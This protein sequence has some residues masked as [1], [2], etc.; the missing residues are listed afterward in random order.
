M[1]S[2]ARTDGT[3]VTDADRADAE[4]RLRA[5]TRGIMPL[6][7][8]MQFVVT[9]LAGL[10]VTSSARAMHGM[11]MV[12]WIAGVTVAVTLPLVM[13]ITKVGTGRSRDQ[14]ALSFAREREMTEEAHRREFETRLAN[15]LE[16]ADDEAEVLS[17]VGRALRDLLPDAS[18]E[19]LLADNSHAHL[20]RSLVIGPNAEGPG[21]TVESP[22]RCVAARRGQT[23]T[24]DDSENL[25]ACSHLRDRP[26]GRCAAM[27][28]P[29]SIMGRTVG[30][31]HRADPL[32]TTLDLSTKLQVEV[33]A[34]QMGA[35]IGM[36]RV[37]VESQ[38]QASTDTVTGLM[39]RRAFEARVRRLRQDGVAYAMVMADLDHFKVLNDTYG[40][41]T[42]DRALRMFS[43]VL[44]QGFRPDDLVCRYGGEEFAIAL[45][46]CSSEDAFAACERLR[47]A[48]V[49]ASQVGGTPPFTASYGVAMSNSELSH[50]QLI[51]ASDGA[52]Y[53]AKRGGRNQT[54][55]ADR[56]EDRQAPVDAMTTDQHTV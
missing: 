48:L 52:L 33:L 10:L 3:L 14:L 9:M 11:W 29:V 20:Q 22:D 40:H 5:S 55:L 4:Q 41:E 42:G 25:D 34:N 54:V 21:C 35:R 51:A 56:Y 37:M 46:S 15:A 49:L 44:R 27:C 7:L 16:M 19:V 32:S 12:T 50:E 1:R 17:S 39:N 13:I 8:V 43:S 38:L 28:V 31:V 23:Q 30:V 2:S 45:P 36:L 24:F 47:D 53:R 6:S 18:V 26:Y